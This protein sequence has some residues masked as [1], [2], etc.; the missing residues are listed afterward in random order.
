[1]RTPEVKLNF[2]P[3]I[4]IC[5]EEGSRIFIRIFSVHSVSTTNFALSGRAIP[6]PLSMLHGKLLDEVY[7]YHC[8]VSC[9]SL[10]FT[11]RLHFC[12]SWLRIPACCPGICNHFAMLYVQPPPWEFWT[13][14]AFWRGH[15]QT[16]KFF[17]VVCSHCYER[18]Y[19]IFVN[20]NWVDTRWQ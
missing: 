15:R 19:D 10:Y 12:C 6:P 11:L 18:I 8:P 13:R 7:L 14:S 4:Y 3:K 17:K 9:R 16:L 20:C 2:H 5:P 1:M